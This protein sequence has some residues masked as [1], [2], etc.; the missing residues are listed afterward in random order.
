[1]SNGVRERMWLERLMLETDQKAGTRSRA[2]YERRRM[3][4]VVDD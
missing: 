4:P 3:V 1:M 2:D